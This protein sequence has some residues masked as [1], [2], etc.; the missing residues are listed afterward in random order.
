MSQT[1]LYMIACLILLAFSA[2]AK[3]FFV[4][5]IGNDQF[6]GTKNQPYQTIF[7]ASETAMPSDN[8]TFLGGEYQLSRQFRP[9][10]SGL[11]YKCILYRGAPGQTVVFD[12]SLIKKVAQGGDSVQFSR[13]TAGLFQIEKVNYLR[14]ENIAVLHR[15]SADVWAVSIFCQRISAMFSYTAT[16]ATK[17]GTTKW[18][19]LLLLKKLQ[20][21]WLIKTL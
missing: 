16:S 1:K 5:A 12:G 7:K 20:K 9:V 15:F 6:Q 8:L 13:Q 11:P 2:K 10:R 14:F 4:D 3:E 21:P 17:A 19:S 18:G